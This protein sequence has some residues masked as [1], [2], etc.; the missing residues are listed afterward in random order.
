MIYRRLTHLTLVLALAGGLSNAL[1]Q[2]SGG[3]APGG[4]NDAPVLLQPGTEGEESG[5]IQSGGAASGGTASGGTE[6]GGAQPVV[7]QP[8]S[9]ATL[10]EGVEREV[11]VEGMQEPMTLAI[12]DD[13]RVFYVERLGNVKLWSEDAGLQDVHTFDVYTEEEHGLMGIA[14]D[15]EFSSNSYIYIYYTA[16]EGEGNNLLS[17]F[18]YSEEGGEPSLDVE[19]EEVLLE[20]PSDRDTCCHQ[21]GDLEF[22]PDGKLYL[23]TG[24]NTN[25]FESDG[26]APIDEREGRAYFNALRTAPN[27]NDLRGKILRL[28]KDGSVPEDN[29]FVDTPGARPEIYALGFR[30]PFRFIVDP[31]TGWLL[32]GN[33]GPDAEEPAPERGP[34]GQDE[35]HVITEAGQDAGWPTCIGDNMPYEDW[36]FA[37]NTSEGTFDCSG[38]TP[39]VIW[40]PYGPSEEFPELD[41]GGLDEEALDEAR[42][43]RN[44]QGGPILRNIDGAEYTWGENYTDKWLIYEW[45]RNF[46]KLATLSEDGTEVT[47]IEPFI[48]NLAR[49]MDLKQG[50]DGALYL[51]EYGTNWFA[52]NEDARLSRITSTQD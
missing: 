44:A 12:A 38:K 22:G 23:S 34:A 37:T 8:A 39:A 29:P 49:P 1:A 16:A 40:Y 41:E 43:G 51:L 46:I 28:N 2:E 45:Q 30:N 7:V 52:P 21:A 36:N 9:A 33:V 13:G 18:T 15:P 50:P 3:A 10:P 11:L 25:P 24:D 48:S 42:R 19:S 4:E 20:V 5:G 31:E 27:L 47:A 14:L 6:S 35:W 32:V 26:Y 17:R